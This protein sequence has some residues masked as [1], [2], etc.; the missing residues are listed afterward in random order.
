MAMLRQSQWIVE[1]LAAAWG[2][3]ARW[4]LDADPQ[5]HEA[6]Y[7]KLDCAK[8]RSRLGWVPRWPLTKAIRRI[9]AWQQA[10]RAGAD[11]RAWSLAEIADYVD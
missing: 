6:H 7:L 11:M 5:P 1:C 4:R 2:S 9:V 3:E 8:A 10:L